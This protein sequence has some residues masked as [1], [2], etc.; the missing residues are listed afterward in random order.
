LSHSRQLAAIM[1]TDIVGYTALMEQDEKKAFYVLKKNLALHQSVISEFRGR[2]IKEMGD[3]MLASFSNVSDALNAA[4][5]IQNL[6][7]NANEYKLSIG[8]HQGEV[9]FENGDVFG[10]AVNVASRIQSLGV[11]GSILFSKKITDEIKN[12][13]EFQILS[14]GSFEFKNVSEPV[15]VFALS[16]DGLPVPQRSKMQGKLKK[17]FKNRNLTIVF[18]TIFILALTVA[19]YYLLNGVKEEDRRNEKFI[20]ILPFTNL[21]NDSSQSYFS[22]GMTEDILIHLSKIADLTV[23]SPTTTQRYKGSTL[24]L[25]QIGIELGV[26]T[27]VEGSVRRQG[28]QVRINIRLIDVETE[29]TIWSETFDRSLDDVFALQSEIAIVIANSLK[30]KLTPNEKQRLVKVKTTNQNAYD[31]F[32]KARQLFKDNLPKET[33]EEILQLLNKSIS[34]DSKF[35]PAYGLKARTWAQMRFF[36]YPPEIW[37]DSAQYFATMA[38]ELDPSLPDGYFIRGFENENGGEVD[39]TI[40]FGLAANYPD[41]GGILGELQVIFYNNKKGADFVLKHIEQQYNAS[42]PQYFVQW[43]NA[44]WNAHELDIAEKLFKKVISMDSNLIEP[45]ISL[46]GIYGDTKRF[47]EELKMSEKCVQ[48]MPSNPMALMGHSGAYYHIG[49][50]DK[51]SQCLLKVISA[52]ASFNDTTQYYPV[53]HR[54]AY[55][56]LKKGRKD[57]AIVYANKQIQLDL[58]KLRGL[59]GYGVFGGKGNSYYDL[60]ASFSLLGDKEKGIQ[61]LD[62]AW[63]FGQRWP[64]GYRED[65]LLD[66]LRDDKR[67]QTILKKSE[68]H[69]KYVSNAYQEALNNSETAKRV[70]SMIDN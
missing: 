34:A 27:L 48:L 24:S 14:I 22:E 58:G 9:V 31:H 6:C 45:Y 46:K 40:A 28:S 39:H 38:I 67:F 68:N 32:L 49:D 4:I 12:K 59:R 47:N 29:T 19:G 52:E 66:N 36:G 8:I 16:N 61:Y 25:S 20:A 10:D 30:A 13:A 17:N 26:G 64:Q 60:A 2:I 23:K 70:K 50:I 37:S 53:R 41:L 1:F 44:F 43:A 55:L 21:N 35:A 54:L 57:E 5:K 69:E 51:A 56:L 18:L 63:N 65:P 3:G 15:E 7:N 62:S 11:A 33:V 42:D